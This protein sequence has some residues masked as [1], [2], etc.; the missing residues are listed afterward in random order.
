MNFEMDEKYLPLISVLGSD[1]KWCAF[2]RCAIVGDK[3]ERD[4]LSVNYPGVLERNM[5]YH[6]TC[7]IAIC[8]VPKMVKNKSKIT[9]K[10]Y[11]RV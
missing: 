7:D 6:K 9:L 5:Y 11:K 8:G 3:Y 10:P 2:F 4:L 1:L